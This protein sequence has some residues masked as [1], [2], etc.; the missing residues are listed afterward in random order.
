MS[1]L[2]DSIF[3]SW[4]Q[5]VAVESANNDD[6][7]NDLE[8]ALKTMVFDDFLEELDEDDDDDDD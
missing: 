7:R 8:E 2:W 6:V 3:G 5:E 4:R 1:S